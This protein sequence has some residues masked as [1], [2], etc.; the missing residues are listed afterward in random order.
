MCSDKIYYAP[1]RCKFMFT[2][3]N[4]DGTLNGGITSDPNALPHIVE[5]V[6]DL[7][8]TNLVI[9]DESIYKKV[10]NSPE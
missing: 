5:M 4:A 9:K 3:D 6:R 2:F 1:F 10:T 7:G 8:G